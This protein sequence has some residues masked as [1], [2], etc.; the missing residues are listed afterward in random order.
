[1]PVQ[2]EQHLTIFEALTVETMPIKE[3]CLIAMKHVLFFETF[4][5][6]KLSSPVYTKQTKGCTYAQIMRISQGLHHRD[7]QLSLDNL[8]R[9]YQLFFESES[10]IGELEL[11][12]ENYLW[13]PVVYAEKRSS[14]SLP[15]EDIGELIKRKELQLQKHVD[16]QNFE[17][18]ARIRDEI[19]QLKHTLKHSSS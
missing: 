16:H 6:I 7:Y 3:W 17:T 8:D 18:A 9:N 10:T 11:F 19:E 13:F 2:G 4:I 5:V 1:M 12:K 15:T 14:E